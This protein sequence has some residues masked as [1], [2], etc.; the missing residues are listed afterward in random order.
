MQKSFSHKQ[1]ND[2]AFDYPISG[3]GGF[4]IESEQQ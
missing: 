3:G 1:Y 2:P 4:D